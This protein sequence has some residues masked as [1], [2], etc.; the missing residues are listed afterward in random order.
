MSDAGI[1]W[2]LEGAPAARG[3]FK[4]AASFRKFLQT[5]PENLSSSRLITAIDSISTAIGYRSI[6]V[7]WAK[8]P[9]HP[10]PEHP[11]YEMYTKLKSTFASRIV[12]FIADSYNTRFYDN[13]S[14]VE[15]GADSDIEVSP[16]DVSEASDVEYQEESLPQQRLGGQRYRDAIDPRSGMKS[17][18]A[19]AAHGNVPIRAHV[20][21]SAPIVLSV[22]SSLYEDQGNSWFR[23]SDNVRSFAG[24]VLIPTYERGD[25][26]STAET[27]AALEYFLA[28]KNKEPVDI[29]SPQECLKIGLDAMAS[30]TE[31]DLKLA[32]EQKSKE[33]L[34]KTQ[35]V[36]YMG[37]IDDNN[38]LGILENCKN[39]VL[40]QN[41]LTG[42]LPTQTNEKLMQWL[43]HSKDKTASTMITQ[44]MISNINRSTKTPNEKMKDLCDLYEKIQ[45]HDGLRA[46]RGFHRIFGA[47]GNTKLFQQVAKEVKDAALNLLEQTATG[48]FSGEELDKV[49]G[50]LNS[51]RARIPTFSTTSSHS[52]HLN[53]H[54]EGFQELKQK[55]AAMRQSTAVAPKEKIAEDDEKKEQT[56]PLCA[57]DSETKT[58]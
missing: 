24:A 53:A 56:M 37:K 54:I 30:A 45:H 4:D 12:P 5:P 9:H 34:S 48:T 29:K 50:V 38:I 52:P 35:A 46:E 25:F 32:I 20:S 18:P 28:V 13:R 22:I 55:Y 40:L 42:L 6:A 26:H 15:A 36:D 39:T 10:P 3:G 57:S 31:G 47:T 8:P 7:G 44:Q 1:N 33:L 51:A 23:N 21:G 16:D 41:I 17:W 14:H 49:K 19:A 2:L 11:A 27:A 58:R 43:G